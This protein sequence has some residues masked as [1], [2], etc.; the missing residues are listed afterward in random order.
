MIDQTAK[1]KI[2]QA[3]LAN[4]VRKV[5]AGKPLATQERKLI[6]AAAAE[7]VDAGTISTPE[8][9]SLLAKYD[10]GI[11]YR[12]LMMIAD[13]GYFSKPIEGR[14]KPLDVALGLARWYR[15]GT[16]DKEREKADAKRIKTQREV[17]L[18][19]IKIAEKRREL[20]Q[21][22]E[23][24]RAWAWLAEANRAIIQSADMP[25]R[26][27]QDLLKNLEAIPVEKYLSESNQTN[28]PTEKEPTE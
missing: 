13:E 19:D 25:E 5:K 6:T 23:V 8:L 22:S 27:K 28:Q 21:Y 18:L 16:N 1:D 2:L 4:V 20:V 14:W 12:Q 9:E 17:E 24:E 11:K 7:S 10:V 26:T 15:R 3:D